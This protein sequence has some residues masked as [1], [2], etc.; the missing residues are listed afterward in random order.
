MELFICVKPTLDDYLCITD[1]V[2]VIERR[3]Q[4][5][6]PHTVQLFKEVDHEPSNISIGVAGT[7]F[8]GTVFG[9]ILLLDLARL[10]RYVYTKL[11]GP[12]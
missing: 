3:R 11:T 4:E 5:L 1:E 9:L 12:K 10:A 7:A 6:L 8:I 2:S